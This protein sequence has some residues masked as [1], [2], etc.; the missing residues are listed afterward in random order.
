MLCETIVITTLGVD[1][2]QRHLIRFWLLR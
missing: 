2:S 1:A